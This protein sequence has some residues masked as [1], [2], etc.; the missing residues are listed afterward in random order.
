MSNLL[1]RRRKAEAVDSA[2]AGEN[3]LDVVRQGDAKRR[4]LTGSPPMSPLRPL[5]PRQSPLRTSPMRSCRNRPSPARPEAG[6]SSIDEG[7]EEEEKEEEEK[8]PAALLA[9][10]AEDRTDS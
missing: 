4:K 7:K 1:G 3:G 2:N 9:D 6:L 8:F 5:R 10:E